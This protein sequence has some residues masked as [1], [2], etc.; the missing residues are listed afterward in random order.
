[1]LSERLLPLVLW[2]GLAL[3][4]VML[5][6]LLQIALLRI[7]LIARTTREQHFLQTWRPL[8]AAAIAGENPALPPLA[9]GDEVFFL[10]LWNHLQESLRGDAKWRLNILA[11]RCGVVSY[12]HTL[13]RQTDLRSQLLAATTLG[14]LNDRSPWEGILRLANSPDPLLSLVAARALL[15]LDANAVLHDLKRQLLEREDW[16]IAQLTKML[17]ETG[18][19]ATFA[20]LADTAMQLASSTDP[21]ELSQLRRVLQLLEV[22]PPQLVVPVVRRILATTGDDEAIAHCLRFLSEPNDLPTVRAHLA[23]RNWKIRLQA[24]LALGRIGTADDVVRLTALLGDP[25]WWVRYRTAQALVILTRGNQQTL[26]RLRAQ[27]TDRYARDMLEMA[28]AE[29]DGR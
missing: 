26:S 15:Q 19:A 21:A 24:A 1:M 7:N 18:T 10:K 29:K 23:H 3:L 11:A 16:P 28:M 27:L 13:L 4:V 22:A 25:V 2:V 5:L 9:K 8:L 14:H 17:Q 20:E 12:A 6:L